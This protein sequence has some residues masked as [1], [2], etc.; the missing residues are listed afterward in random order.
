L[1]VEGVKNLISTLA[2]VRKELFAEEVD[3]FM[4]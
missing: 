3:E 2:I 1:D 4:V